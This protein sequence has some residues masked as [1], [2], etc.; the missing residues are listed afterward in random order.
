MILKEKF[1]NLSF[2]LHALTLPSSDG[3][4]E[5]YAEIYEPKDTPVLGVVQLLHGMVDHVGRY[6][7][8]AEFLC[9]RGYVFAGHCH[10]GHGKS[11]K[12]SSELGFFAKRNG[13]R[14]VLTDASLMNALLHERYEGLPIVMMGHSMGSYIARIYAANYPGTID[15]LVIHATGGP[16]VVVGLGRTLVHVMSAVR[17]PRHRS[18]LMKKLANLGYNSK[19]P[20]EEG[21]A[22]WL[23]RDNAAARAKAE[24]EYASFAFTLSA[25]GD[26]FRFVGGAN[27]GKCFDAHPKALPTLIVSG[28]M[29]PLGDF[30][31]G[32]R[33]VYSELKKR[34]VSDLTLKIYEG[35]R[36]EL[37]NEINR[38]EIFADIAA[39]LSGE[40]F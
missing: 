5:L 13:A 21:P 36:H 17:G 9:E 39:W 32:V 38:E 10:L 6:R 29:D 40:R 4:H 33:R 12:D 14:L 19:F 8:L 31:R 25:Y 16:S 23:T 28:D 2:D 34:G 30:G 22:A 1:G 11:A 15:G 20:K 37:F 3:I 7:A 18:K 26:L 35:A 27:S 24:D